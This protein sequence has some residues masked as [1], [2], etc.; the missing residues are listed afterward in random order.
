MVIFLSLA[1]CTARAT[2][3][4][5]SLPRRAMEP[6]SGP[7]WAMVTVTPAGAAGASAFFG[8][9]SGRRRRRRGGDRDGEGEL[10]GTVHLGNLL[11][12]YLGECGVAGRGGRGA[13]RVKGEIMGTGRGG[14]NL[15]EGTEARESKRKKPA[16]GAGFLPLAGAYVLTWRRPG[17]TS[18][19]WRYRHPRRRSGAS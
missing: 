16:R 13:G 11:K 6:V 8:S 2:P 12:G 5:S 19:A 18:P 9:S 14:V 10:G 1:C 4:S 7:A 17:S 15:S 3:F